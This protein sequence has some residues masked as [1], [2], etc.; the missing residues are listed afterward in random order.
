MLSFF[1]RKGGVSTTVGV[2]LV[3][4][5]PLGSPPPPPKLTKKKL[6]D[7]SSQGLRTVVY[8]ILVFLG[9]RVKHVRE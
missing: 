5:D 9:I 2:T 7:S 8:E 1:S 4:S 3:P 6:R